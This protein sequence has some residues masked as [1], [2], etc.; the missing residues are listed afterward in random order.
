I[1]FNALV[2]Y[3][4]GPIERMIDAQPIIQSAIVASRRIVEILDLESEENEDA[5]TEFSFSNQIMI[6]NLYFNYGHREDLLKDINIIINKNDF[7]AL[8]GESGSGK[9]TLAKLLVN[10]Y[11]AKEGEI[12]FDQRNILEIE[13][14]SIRNN[15]GYVSQQN[16]F[17]SGTIIENLLIGNDGGVTMDE[18]ISACKNAE[19]HDFIET[20]PQRY[21]TSLEANGDNLSGGQL[22]RLALA[23]LY[24]KNPD[25]YILDEVTSSLDATTENKIINNLYNTSKSK[26]TVI[27]ISHKL[28]TIEK[29]DNIY[30]MKNGKIIEQGT[31]K[32]LLANRSEY[33]TLWKNQSTEGI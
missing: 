9:S 20:L 19:I 4:L 13:N 5:L 21:N 6:N 18:I 7:V 28:S 27:L 23:R 16:F 31:H 10:Y 30:C 17:F 3:F 32:Q 2:V 8:V 11:Q 12:Q 22:Q 24:I 33:Y 1:T 25:I 26:K 15:I 14:S 29:V